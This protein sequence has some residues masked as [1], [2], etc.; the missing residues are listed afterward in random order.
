M[1]YIMDLAERILY[2]ASERY[3]TWGRDS[4]IAR[5]AGILR[6]PIVNEQIANAIVRDDI[7]SGE[8]DQW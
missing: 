4:D 6:Q 1:E 8:N 7:I 2:Y 5:I 3:E